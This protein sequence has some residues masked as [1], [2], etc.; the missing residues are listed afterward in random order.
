MAR[1][2]L[3]LSALA[4]AV[5][6]QTAGLALAEHPLSHARDPLYYNGPAALPD[7]IKPPSTLKPPAPAAKP[8]ASAVSPLDDP[9]YRFG[10]GKPQARP[11]YPR[12]MVDG[13][14]IWNTVDSPEKRGP[15]AFLGNRIGDPIGN[16][17]PHPDAEKDQFG[18]LLCRDTPGVPGFLDCADDS[19]REFVGGRWVLMFRGIE[20]S[21]LNYK[22][23]DGKLVGFDLGFPVAGFKKMTETVDRI[24]GPPSKKDQFDWRNLRGAGVDVSM[25]SWHT[26]H[27]T[28]V[29]RSHGAALD[30]GALSLFETR[31]EQRYAELRDK[32][33]VPPAPPPKPAAFY[34]PMLR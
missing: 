6:L 25:L 31:A 34:D 32:Q 14:P 27:G 18:M 7:E 2:P 12:E 4:L 24:Y 13:K 19:L 8:P 23:L 33:V 17:F 5:L 11:N 3:L 1:A 26:P 16:L 29:L 15:F 20:A 9:E 10:R 28:M 30:S 22:Y 21:F